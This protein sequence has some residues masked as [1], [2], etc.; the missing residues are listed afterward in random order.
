MAIG[1]PLPSPAFV[2]SVADTLG[3]TYDPVS[4]INSWDASFD[5]NVSEYDV[6]QLADPIEVTGRANSTMTFG[7]YLADSTDSGQARILSHE[8]AK[9]FLFVKVLW[10]GTNGF[11]AKA[12]V[13]TK[14]I[15]NRAG[16]NLAEVQYTF[17]IVPSSIAIVG[18]GPIL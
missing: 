6:F 16:P 4:L 10:D 3:G 11:T 1:N 7:G 8:T 13:N 12:R 5:E 14:R 9:D 18:T 15:S 17:T 2:L